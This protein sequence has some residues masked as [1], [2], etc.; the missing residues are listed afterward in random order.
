[1]APR[2]GRPRTPPTTD[3][4]P[5]PPAGRNCAARSQLAGVLAAA[6]FDID[7]TLVDTT[8]AIRE[9]VTQVLQEE[10]ITPTWEEIKA[11]WSL[12]AA[13]RMELWVRDRS[14]AEDFGARYLE[15]Y[16]ALQDSLTR[17]S[18]G[19]AETL[20]R[21]AAR[22]IPLGVVTSKRRVSALRTLVAFDLERFFRVIVT[23]EDV[24]APKPDPGPLL[25]AV[26]R[27]VNPSSRSFC[28]SWAYLPDSRHRSKARP[29]NPTARACVLR[30]ARLSA[31]WCRK[32]RS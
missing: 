9:A 20:G 10:G 15:R 11:G 3:R 31:P 21:L 30:S 16:L 28:T 23:E 18:P 29:S 26:T 13:D 24:P 25:L 32:S 17:P 27:Y 5:A 1:M 19:R 7:G 2:P 22:G 12:R 4:P 6:L 14:R 8:A